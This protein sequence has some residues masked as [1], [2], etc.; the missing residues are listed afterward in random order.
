MEHIKLV[1]IDLAKS[2]YQVCGFSVEN[3]PIFNKRFKRSTFSEF[4]LKLEPTNIYMEACYSSHYWGR[5]LQEQGHQVYLIPAQHV[6]PFVRGNK[7]DSNDAIAIAEAAQRPNIKF[8]PIKSIVQQ[9]ILSL[10]RVRERLVK[11][12]TQLTN[13]LR[14]L[15]VDF[16][17]VIPQGFKAF[18]E[19]IPKVV[20]NEKL[21][22]TFRHELSY[23]LQ[24]F[25]QVNERLTSI[26][27]SIRAL[28][29]YSPCY[30]ILCS[31]PGFGLITASALF[32][33]IDKGQA[34][35]S[36]KALAVWLGITP[37]H[38][39]SGNHFHSGGISKRGD[40]YLR[41]QI[42]HGARAA[43]RWAKK[44]DDQF[45]DWVNHLVVRRGFNKAVVAVAHKMVR[46]AWIL[47]QRNE[48][49]KL[50]QAK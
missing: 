20:D 14:G 34:F 23:Y 43:M 19:V 33:S 15:L 13:Q 48:P 46:I 8:V 41:K 4:M 35:S 1:S 7:N 16:G 2:V 39:A 21:S 37:T 22:L 47:L 10:H 36:A 18:R 24:E 11:N 27:K 30:Q 26:E 49:F 50:K 6:K 9:E 29:E 31:I 44:R 40:R 25:N 28:C 32:A 3:K 12:R 5:T 42:I 38:R 17:M 45:S